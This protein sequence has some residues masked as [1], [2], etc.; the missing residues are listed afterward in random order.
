MTAIIMTRRRILRMIP[1]LGLGAVL[2]GCFDDASGP[3]EIKYGR[4]T[5]TMCNMIISDYRFGAQVRGG[6]KNKVFKFD[7]IGGAIHWLHDQD[8]GDGEDVEIWVN[9]YE[10]GKAWLDARKAFWITG[11]VSPMDYGFAAVSTDRPGAMPFAEAQRRVMEKGPPTCAFGAEETR[12]DHSG[13]S[14]Q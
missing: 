5:C 7:D 8:W 4:D 3:A 11:V 6:P 10:E 9:D 12:H 13:K 14:A 1:A 2:A